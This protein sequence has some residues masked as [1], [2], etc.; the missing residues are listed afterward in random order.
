MGTRRRRAADGVELLR[1]QQLRGER[2]LLGDI[3]ARAD[4]FEEF[5]L[6][7]EHQAP[8]EFASSAIGHRRVASETRFESA[9]V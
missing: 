7:I 6:L 8:R 9:V 2:A 1:L 4:P 5:A 3:V